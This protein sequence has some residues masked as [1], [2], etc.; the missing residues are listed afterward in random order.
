MKINNLF[1]KVY[2]IENFNKKCVKK[3]VYILITATN[4]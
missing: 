3:L 2:I 1:I 4:K